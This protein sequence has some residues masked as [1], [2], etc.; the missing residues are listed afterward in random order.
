MPALLEPRGIDRGDGKRPDGITITP[1]TNG[2]SLAW[3]ATCTNTFN[4]TIVAACAVDPGAAARAAEQ[5][6]RNH[7]AAIA[8]RYRF[9]PLAVETTGVLGPAI[10]KFLAELGRRIS[11]QTGEKRE[12]CWL[13]QR[14][15][16][17]IVRG[18]AAAIAIPAASN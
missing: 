3:D 9:E 4:S 6:K 15:S 10:S 13:R 18:N 11:A 1:F 17:A 7:Y 14:I 2:K 12:T 8:R 5:R 16:L